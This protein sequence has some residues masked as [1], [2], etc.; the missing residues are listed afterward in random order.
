MSPAARAGVAAGVGAAVYGS[1]R[2]TWWFDNTAE[3]A[4]QK[5]RVPFPRV[6][7]GAACGLWFC[8]TET[9]TREQITKKKAQASGGA[10]SNRPHPNRQTAPR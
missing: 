8:R 1:W 2:F 4:L 9:A 5:L 10:P 3:Q 6:V 7:M